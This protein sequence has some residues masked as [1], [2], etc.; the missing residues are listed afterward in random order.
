MRSAWITQ[1]RCKGEG[2]TWN[3]ATTAGAAARRPAERV[4]STATWAATASTKCSGQTSS[5][6]LCRDEEG[7]PE[8]RRPRPAAGRATGA[9]ASSP[10]SPSPPPP[11]RS[12]GELDMD[13]RATGRRGGVLFSGHVTV[14]IVGGPPTGAWMGG[15]KHTLDAFPHHE[16][17]WL[18][19]SP[20]LRSSPVVAYVVSH[21]AYAMASL[22][23]P[24]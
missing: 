7:S 6:D 23:R 21:A 11:R 1:R 18:V 12:G 20:R 10:L 9:A 13:A 16:T 15:R 8:R 24:R 17:I 5:A 4:A 14:G 22:L 2:K 19:N 3:T